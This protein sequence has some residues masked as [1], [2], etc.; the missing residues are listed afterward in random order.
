MGEEARPCRKRNKEEKIP[1]SPLFLFA[2]AFSR[3]ENL[4]ETRERGGEGGSPA[5]SE[6]H[7][8]REKGTKK[9]GFLRTFPEKNV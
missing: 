2:I 7:L 8:T 4:S 1:F 6:M 9:E 3:K 5:I